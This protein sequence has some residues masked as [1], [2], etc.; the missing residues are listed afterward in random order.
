MSAPSVTH[1]E[2]NQMKL[3]LPI[4]LVAALLS[5]SS[6]SALTDAQ[7]CSSFKWKV[8]GGHAECLLKEDAKAIKTGKEPDYSSCERKL[9][10]KYTRAELK[11]ACDVE[12]EVAN[13]SNLLNTCTQGVRNTTTSNALSVVGVSPGWTCTGPAPDNCEPICGDSLTVG[14]EFCDDGNTTGSDGCSADCLSGCGDSV[15]EPAEGEECDDGNSAT[16]DGCTPDCIVESCGD[17]VRQAS[18]ACDDFNND[19][20]DGCSADCQSDETC[21][22][23]VVDAV[24]GEE[25][26]S[27]GDECSE[28]CTL[29]TTCSEPD[30][31]MY[32]GGDD[33]VVVE[34]YGDILGGRT[35]IT[36][37]A[38]VRLDAY[39]DAEI[40]GRSPGLEILATSCGYFRLGVNEQG[41][42]EVMRWSAGDGVCDEVV[43]LNEWTHLAATMDQSQAGR[44][45]VFV[46]GVEACAGL[47]G[48]GQ[49]PGLVADREIL[50][51]DGSGKV[52]EERLY[53]GAQPDSNCL[54]EGNEPI[55]EYFHHGSIASVRI[56]D[57]FRYTGTFSP[58]LQLDS[59]AETVL[60]YAMN[61]ISGGV[62]PDDSGIGKDATVSG[63]VLS[64]GTPCSPA[65]PQQAFLCGVDA[66]FVG[67]GEYA[68][69]GYALCGQTDATWVG[70]SSACEG[71][72][73]QLAE[74]SQS[75]VQSFLVGLL[76]DTAESFWL[77][78]QEGLGGC[79]GAWNYCWPPWSSVSDLVSAG[80][81]NWASGQPTLPSGAVYIEAASGEWFTGSRTEEPLAGYFCQG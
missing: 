26:D 79:N 71:Q 17:G 63:A 37:E 47:A 40:E 57:G 75:G 70:S 35:E 52:A 43:P 59:D 22:N 16:D 33:F 77:G 49:P 10:I 46:N 73:G 51:W 32:F 61:D 53:I 30:R 60:L 25:C 66:E 21:G 29:V 62:L 27:A 18:E 11:W 14:P 12:G 56:S 54:H 9:T 39:P 2:E 23:G 8:A 7:K 58:E 42:V 6:A 24:T 28:A 15:F 38:W 81:T 31:S 3:I 74:V 1:P 41:R 19:D 34:P 44:V 80:Y 5:P 69:T 36:F 50:G 20:G 55:P 45:R 4:L 78:A 64:S 13:V 68:G 72:G 67:G 65:I 48:E 76:P